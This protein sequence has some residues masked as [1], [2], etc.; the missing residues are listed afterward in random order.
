MVEIKVDPEKCNGCGTCV[1]VCPVSVYE[2]QDVEGS[3]KSVPVN[4]DA[5][6]VCRS[7][8]VQCPNQAITVIE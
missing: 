4:K 3:K 2:L 6:I 8:E 5:C 1:E 7:C